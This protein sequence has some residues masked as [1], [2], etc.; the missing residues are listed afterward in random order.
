MAGIQWF[1]GHM[2]KTRRLIAENLNQVDAVIEVLDA[3]SPRSSE[4]PEIENIISNKPRLVILNKSDLADTKQTENWKKFYHAQGVACISFSTKNKNC[5]KIFKSEVE[6]LMYEKLERWNARG[7]PGRNI[8]L[9]IVGIPNVG[10][11]AIINRL[12][13]NSK[14]KVE[15][16]P[17][18]TRKNQWFSAVGNLQ[19]LDT[20]GVLWPKFEDRDVA[21][22]LAFT[23]SIKDQILDIE[24]LA[25]EFIDHIK[26]DYASNICERFK[27]SKDDFQN[28]DRQNYL[29]AIAKKRGMIVSGGQAD[30]LRAANMIMEEFRSG[31]LGKITLERA[32]S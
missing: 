2:A 4:N 8:K 10:K 25:A 16:R 29:S 31:K 14:A 26:S 32:E 3:R 5:V 30:T 22:N 7:M 13:G 27:L 12:V 15:N 6:N 21:F 24:D 1:P 17:G 11:S 18:V 23:G 28:L 19:I 20:P 9:M